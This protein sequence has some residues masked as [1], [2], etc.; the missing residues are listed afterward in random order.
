MAS[1][2]APEF[3]SLKMEDVHVGDTL[4][5]DNGFTCHEPGPVVI[6]RD[7]EGALFFKCNNGHHYIDG[8][9]D[10]FGTLIGMK[11]ETVQ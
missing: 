9:E 8:Q 5:L 10:E 3:R 2:T 1:K 7:G 4:V 6:M 11:R